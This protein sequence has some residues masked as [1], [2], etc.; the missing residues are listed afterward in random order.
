ME[1]LEVT[2]TRRNDTGELV[3]GEVENDEAGEVGNGRGDG[4]GEGVVL[5]EERE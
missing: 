2:D 5:E 4:A 3:S 1:L